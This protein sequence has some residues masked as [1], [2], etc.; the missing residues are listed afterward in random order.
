M[1]RDLVLAQDGHIAEGPQ[2][3]SNHNEVEYAQEERDDDHGEDVET[4]VVVNRVML[5]KLREPG[6]QQ[7]DADKGEHASRHQPRPLGPEL[8]EGL[9][10]PLRWNVWGRHGLQSSSRRWVS[11]NSYY[12]YPS[13]KMRPTNRTPF[14]QAQL[15][16]GWN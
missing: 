12:C 3:P 11:T 15:I 14:K 6:H 16:R 10:L 2:T 4:V 13:R 1:A 8:G 9:Y 5:Q 7:K